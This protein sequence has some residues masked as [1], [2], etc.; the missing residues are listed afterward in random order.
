MFELLSSWKDAAPAV[1]ACTAI[2]TAIVAL[3]V[4]RHT[5]AANRRRATLDMVMKTL[6]DSFAQERYGDFKKVIRKD[7]DAN[8]PFKI[9]S[10]LEATADNHQ[11]R[12]LVLQQLNIYEMTSLGIRRKLFDED[13]YKR[14]FHNQFMTDFENSRDFIE[15]AQAK[16]G[17]VYCEFTALYTRWEKS[18]HPISSPSKFKFAYWGLTGQFDKIDRAREWN[19]AR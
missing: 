13:F 16:K 3:L 15:G 9:E 17:S 12:E 6:M 5:R 11:D 19:K 7:K 8:D 1:G 4:F 18:G 10:L 2:V 14:W